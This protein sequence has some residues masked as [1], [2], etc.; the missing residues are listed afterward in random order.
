VLHG[1]A[2]HWSGTNGFRLM[3]DDA[4]SVHPAAALVVAAAGGHLTSFA[5][6]WEH[7]TDGP[8]EGLL[9]FGAAEEGVGGVVA[10]WGDSWHQQPAPRPITGSVSSDGREVELEADYGGG[11]SWQIAIQADPGA[12]LTMTMRNV[13]PEDRATA[14][15]AAGPYDVMQMELRPQG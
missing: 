2:G 1:A 4:L 11:W 13:I 3:P 5:Y 9:V 6:T 15:K 14:D 7:P 10:L 12:A 8:Q